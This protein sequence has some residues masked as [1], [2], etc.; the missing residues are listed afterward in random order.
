MVK[1]TELIEKL[2]R[3]AKEK[4]IFVEK[5]QKDINS[6]CLSN[7]SAGSSNKLSVTLGVETTI[8]SSHSNSTI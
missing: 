1:A 2:N 7:E 5:M 6:H 8:T 3:D 4:L